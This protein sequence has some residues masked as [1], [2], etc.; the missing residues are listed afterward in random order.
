M[1]RDAEQGVTLST[2]A[3]ILAGLVYLNALGNP[4]VYDDVL[5]VLYNVSL[6]DPAGVRAFILQNVFRPV[7]NLS[8]LLD[9]AVWG[10]HPAG[11]HVTSVLLHMANVALLFWLAWRAVEDGQARDPRGAAGRRPAVVAVAAATTFAVHPL[12][13]EAVGYVSGRSE[14]LAS[15]FFLG[16]LLALRAGLVR[17]RW[18]WLALGLVLGA[19]G[20]GAKEVAVML[21]FVFLAWDR[22]LLPA[23]P[24]A[25]RRR[26]LRLHLPL[27]AVVSVL[28]LVRA[29]TFLWIET[30]PP[31]TPLWQ[32]VASQFGVVWRYLFLLVAPV[33]QS[34]VH[35]VRP[36]GSLVD[37]P[38][39]VAAATLLGLGALAFRARRAEPLATLGFA[40]LLL[41]LAPSSLIPLHELMAEH[42]VYL[43][44]AGFFLAG[45]AGCGRLWARLAPRPAPG[46]P[47]A[48]GVLALMLVVLSGLTLARNAVWADP[49]RLWREATLNAPEA[50]TAHFGL[51]NALFQRGRCAEA[52]PAYRAAG[53]L[54]RRPYVL[55]NLGTCLV[56]ERR[57][58]E[59]E[60][61]FQAALDLDPRYA[62]AHHNLGLLALNQGD[63]ERA[64]RHFL[65][66]VRPDWRDAEWRQNLVPLYETRF[67]DPAKT[68]ELCRAIQRVAAETA[69]VAECVA[70]SERRLRQRPRSA[71]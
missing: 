50:W 48:V 16:G 60:R 63:R 49:V 41:L 65:Q 42:R 62:P 30:P 7:T 52:I 67:D 27:V 9:H 18:P 69:G 39:L 43:A 8:Y 59:A 4:F 11:Y 46:R 2:L 71:P 35:P 68:L 33:S 66:A 38:A 36:V 24:E 53:R 55:T 34:I 21:P 1:R 28:A 3:A 51:G 26:L 10:F 40:W 17:R 61:A 57:P 56:A 54:T 20:A 29:A 64:H 25:R 13:T 47:L 22:L 19:I 12:M 31:P 32:Y 44:S 14:V 70:R 6:R 15:T 37:G 58:D 5:T 45:G 23:S